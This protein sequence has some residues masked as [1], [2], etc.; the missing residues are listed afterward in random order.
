MHSRSEADSAARFEG[1]SSLT[2]P[3]LLNRIT[4]RIRQSLE[5]EE[6]LSATVAEVRSFLGTD[7]IKIYRFQPEG[8]GLVIAES[9]YENRLPSLLGLNFPADDIPIYARE[10]YL[11]ARQRTII[12]LST[13]QIG[14][15]ALDAVETGEPLEFP[16]LRY[17]PI[18]PCH[19][20]YLMAM[21]VQSSVVVPIVIE[22]G[23]SNDSRFPSLQ[24]HQ[25]LW[26]LLVSHHSEPRVVTENELMFIQSVVDQV[27]VAIGQA[28]LLE[29]IR[30]QA[31]QEANIN[32]ITTLLYTTPSVQ[33]QTALDETVTLFQGSGGR[34]YL[35]ANDGQQQ[36]V[37]LYTSGEQPQQIEPSKNRYIEENLLW[38]KFLNAR[39]M[40][41]DSESNS[42]SKP[43]SVEWMRAMYAL[44]EIPYESNTNSNIWA[45]ADIYREP[46][47]RTLV[48][49]FQ[50]TKIRG[51]LIL[52][53]YFGKEVVGCLTIFREDS[54]REMLWAGE[55]NPDT[56]QLSPRQSFAAWRQIKQGEPQSWK[57]TDIRQ[58]QAL[59]ERFSIAVKHYRLYEQIQTLNVNLE[60]QVKLRTAELEQSKEIANQQRSL[61]GILAKLEQGFDLETIGRTTTEEV[62]HL[63]NVDRV[64]IYR[65]Y[66]DWGG[67]FISSMESAN[68]EWKHIAL[69][70]RAVW[71]DSYLQETQGGRY[72]NREISSVSDIYNA[73]LSE[74][75]IEIL[76]Y[77]SIRAFLVL[78]IFIEQKLWGL[79]GVYTH[80]SPRVWLASEVA[81]S[82]QIT[83]NLG[84]ILDRKQAETKLH[85]AK[86][87]F[88]LAIRA[89][90]DGFWDWNLL[91]GEIYYSP[92]WKEMLG[93]QDSELP[94]SLGTWESLIFPEDYLTTVQLIQ[95]YNAGIVDQ[96][97]IT[98]R[99]HH[100]NGSIVY[101]LSRAIHIKNEQNQVIR[102]ISTHSDITEI[103]KIQEAMETS[104]MQLSSVLNSSLDGIM[105]FRA[106]RNNRG[107]IEDFEW[108][109]ANPAACEMLANQTEDLIGKYLLEE[110]PENRQSGLFERYIQVVETGI[111]M[112]HEFNYE[113]EGKL[114]W[115]QSIAVKLGDGFAMTIRNLTNI[116][117][118]EK[119]LQEA[120][121][122]LEERVKELKQRNTEMILLSEI[123]DFL[124]ACLTI[125]EVCSTISTL[126]ESLFPDCSGGIFIIANS[127]NRLEMVTAWGN[128]F[129]SESTF[130]PKDCWALRRGRVH[131]LG[132][133]RH[134]LICNHIDHKHPPAESLCIPMI[135][136]G[137]TLG[138]MYLSTSQVNR[139]S[140]NRQQLARTISEQ[141]GMA[142]ANLTLRETLQNQSIRDQ[143]TGLFNRRYLEESFNQEIHRAQRNKYSVGIIM[144]DIDHF[145]QVNDTLGH[146]AG[147]FV[148]KE[149]GY[150]L[151]NIIRASDIACRYGGEEMIL[152][153]P[154]SSLEDTAQ[155]AEEIREVI[156]QLTLN[157]N[158][159]KIE[160]FTASFGVASFPT[161]GINS[162][163]VIQA[164]DA[165]LYR[166][167]A[168]G[169]NKVIVA[170]K[171]NI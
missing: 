55:H 105:A 72:K 114:V 15:S 137:E 66:P 39:T 50:K 162:N 7:R 80:S 87:Q 108:L 122:Q 85:Q 159:K 168:A 43:W 146:E 29:Q 74:C 101:I 112:E 44:S 33:L 107:E 97:L 54:D 51:L 91:T 46:L 36:K 3:M 59:S 10:L 130:Q 20:E 61:A 8:H 57:E 123:S 53:L 113:P 136:Q 116:K 5:L 134:E 167:K 145:K 106:V 118:S 158:G 161:Q 128:E 27:S 75:H 18:D 124:Q 171:A 139:L 165:A 17:R 170:N 77:Y 48:S 151:K 152:I 58:A 9:I 26:G 79:L 127:R 104:Q 56:R 82:N 120:N 110:M 86:E 89:S 19:L 169:R 153:L 135:A 41:N 28:I 30:E 133:E 163:T 4:N 69:A 126:V 49:V 47:F 164:A 150:I 121:D 60:E 147:D 13:H 155:K 62:R 102:M 67:E 93:Y 129:C 157:Y 38:Q 70:T 64:A 76:E 99:F 35:P 45:I 1:S 42:G 143:L 117:S 131:R 149:I 37:E 11:R 144:L 32:R 90:H 14:I 34:L 71:N 73:E 160:G 132:S 81:F 138:L 23:T 31:K 94:N 95:D 22:T 166:A 140:E 24:S 156:A 109:L 16:D 96:F 52:P 2:Q 65:F 115:F 142:I 78:P 125:E 119:A 6:I 111:S 68:P 92:R 25:H 100:K 21:G 63:L 84:A 103:V 98:Q 40:S 141:V 148:L 88:E 154:E 83:T 12:D